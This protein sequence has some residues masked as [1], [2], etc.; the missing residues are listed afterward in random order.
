[1]T[2]PLTGAGPSAGGFT[3]A[4]VPQAEADALIWLY[5]NTAGDSWTDNTGWKTDPV[6]DNWFGV[7]VAGG[8]VTQVD[9]DG[10]NLNGNIAAFP[11]DDLA[12]LVD[13]YLY[14]T[15]VA[16]DISGWTLPASLTHLYLNSTNVAGDISGWTLPASLTNLRLYNTTV[17]GDPDISSNTAMRDYR[18]QDCG[19]AQADVDAVLQG[20]YNRRA[21]FTYATPAL[22][23]GGTNA[24]PG[25]VYQP[26]CPPGTGNEY[27][28]ELVND[29]CGDGFN[30]WTITV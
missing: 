22:N 11:I 28:F 4:D 10:N 26:A 13:L 18:Y 2:L 24:A 21:S 19:L 27:R 29:S 17:S 8:H 15:N 6:V 23:I 1:M 9:L 30:K 20:I 25:G 7:T 5:D 14:S 3:P 12:S 16:G